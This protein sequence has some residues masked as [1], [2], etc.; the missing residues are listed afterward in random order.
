MDFMNFFGLKWSDIKD[1]RLT[2]Q[3]Q[4]SNE[5]VKEWT[6]TAAGRRQR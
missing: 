2:V 1:G 3:R 5:G 4:A 6:K